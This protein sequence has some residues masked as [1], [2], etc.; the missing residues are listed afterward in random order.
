MYSG[1][2]VARKDFVL[3][4][5][6]HWHTLNMCILCVLDTIPT[7]MTDS[8]RL[9]IDNMRR[10]LQ[11]AERI[12]KQA[13]EDEFE[14]RERRKRLAQQVAQKAADYEVA[15]ST[16]KQS[17]QEEKLRQYKWVVEFYVFFG[18][19]GVNVIFVELAFQDDVV[20][21]LDRWVSL[22]SRFKCGLSGKPRISCY[23]SFF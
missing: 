15:A 22:V 21:M 10:S 18:R 13:K 2:V 1:K 19:L 16:Q 6:V 9:R 4:L 8:A 20:R 12:I 5:F 23:F 7:R 3:N 17:S 11:E 14:R